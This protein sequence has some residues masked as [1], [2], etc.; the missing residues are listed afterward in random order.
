MLNAE[1]AV[2]NF[3]QY[4]QVDTSQFLRKRTLNF[5]SFR[6]THLYF[7]F[8]FHCEYKFH[9]LFMS[10]HFLKDRK[11]NFKY[12]VLSVLQSNFF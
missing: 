6:T 1:N 12:A 3:A 2:F 11:G 9:F 8:Y 7:S 4:S 10:C 5:G